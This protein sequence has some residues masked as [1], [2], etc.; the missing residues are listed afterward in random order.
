MLS[1]IPTALLLWPL[2]F[3][4]IMFLLREVTSKSSSLLSFPYFLFG[5]HISLIALGL[6]SDNV[7]ASKRMILI[8]FQ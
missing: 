4:I 6:S 3:N 5:M 7:I 8:A 1:P 2:V